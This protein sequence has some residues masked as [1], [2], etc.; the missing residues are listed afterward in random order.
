MLN[1][2]VN[3]E[4][5]KEQ[6]HENAELIKR[7]I[8]ICAGTGCVANGSL[9]VFA[10]F[11]NQLKEKGIDVVLEL[12]KEEGGCDCDK[13]KYLISESGCQGF[14]QMGPLVNIEPDGILYMKVKTNDV[15]EIVEQTLLRNELVERLLYK[16][17]KTHKPCKGHH[18]I[19]FYNKQTRVALNDCGHLD[20]NDINEY[21]AHDGYLAARRAYLDM[22]DEEVC[23]EMIL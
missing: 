22:T 19:D 20:P 10:E 18:E 2:I 6:Y 12:H 5:I 11:E 23:Q 1:K 7:R 13:D 8:I 15:A 16:D 3:L 4:V 17:P 21:I 9:K 14:C